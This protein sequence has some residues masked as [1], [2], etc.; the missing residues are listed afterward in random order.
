[1]K[2][3]MEVFKSPKFDTQYVQEIAPTVYNIRIQH[4]TDKTM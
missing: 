2:I 1:M 4:A 3:C